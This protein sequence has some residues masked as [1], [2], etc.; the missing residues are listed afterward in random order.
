MTYNKH[1]TIPAFSFSTSP[2]SNTGLKLIMDFIPNHTSDKHQ[3]FQ[4][5]QAREE[6]YKDYYIWVD[7]DGITP[8][9]NWV[10]RRTDSR[11]FNQEVD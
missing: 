6:K 5:S 8:P 3:W 4:R 10:R 1:V 2:L 11:M 7:C 9:N